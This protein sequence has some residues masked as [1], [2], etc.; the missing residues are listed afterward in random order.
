MGEEDAEIEGLFASFASDLQGISS[1]SVTDPYSYDDPADDE[2]EQ[3]VPQAPGGGRQ[4]LTQ[5]K[6]GGGYRGQER[7]QQQQPPAPARGAGGQ[8]PHLLA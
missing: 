3:G 6:G 7:Q 8:G 2:Q 4:Q 5:L 1:D